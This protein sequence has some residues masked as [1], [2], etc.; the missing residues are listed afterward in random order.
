MRVN[1]IGSLVSSKI[2][3]SNVVSIKYRPIDLRIEYIIYN[4]KPHTTHNKT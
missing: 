4:T 2:M 3:G 1:R